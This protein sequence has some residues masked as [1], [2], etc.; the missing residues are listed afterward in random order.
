[1]DLPRRNFIRT[2]LVSAFSAGFAL[3]AVRSGFAQKQT[4]INNPAEFPMEAQKEAVFLFKAETFKPYIN[5][6][7]TV[8]NARGEKIELKLRNVDVFRNNHAG[9]YTTNVGQTDSFSMTFTA[10]DE[11]PRFTSI[12]KMDHPALGEFYLF[13]TKRRSEN[14]EFLYDA[15]INHIR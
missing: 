15:V 7:F 9:E 12:H 10:D 14:G 6:I 13:L 11:L 5:S 8:P 4:N 2:G 3:S 1:M